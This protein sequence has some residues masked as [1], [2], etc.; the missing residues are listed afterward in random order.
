M[1]CLLS[2]GIVSR[3]SRRLV[4]R[5]LSC[6]R[7]VHVNRSCCELQLAVAEEVSC[8]GCPRFYLFRL[9]LIVKW[10]YPGPHSHHVASTLFAKLFYFFR[11]VCI[12]CGEK[13]RTFCTRLKDRSCVFQSR[14]K[15]SDI[16]GTQVDNKPSRHTCLNSNT[17]LGI[18]VV[19]TYT[20]R[21]Y[22]HNRAVLR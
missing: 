2:G 22:E 9:S 5:S 3:V 6:C 13:I 10:P 17:R 21:S 4:P 15:L 18:V 14:C 11:T 8:P 16:T 20:A 1:S 12:V 19:F 7:K